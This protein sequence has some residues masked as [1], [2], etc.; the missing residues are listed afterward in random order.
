MPEII[1]NTLYVMTQGAYIHRDHL[2][3]KVEVEK[4]TRLAVPIHHLSSVAVFGSVMVSP[5]A[6]ELCLEAG[7]SLTFLS[8][9]GRLVAR[10]DAPVSGNVLLRREQFRWADRPE[11]CASVARNI[12]AGKLQNTR[13]VLLRGAREAKE[14]SDQAVLTS[15][16]DGIAESFRPLELAKTLDS[17]RG[18][19]GESARRY[20]GAFNH[21]LRQ[22]RAGFSISGRNRR[23]PLDPTNA[24]LSFTYALLLHDCVAAATSAGLDPNV[25]FLHEDR[26]GR[27]SLALD[28]ME[29]FRPLIADRLVLTLIN[30]QEIRVK[31]FKKRD[32]GA[33][34]M[35]DT[36]RK[37]LVTSWQ[38]RKQEEVTHPF[39]DQ[40]TTIG[41]LPF[42]QAKLLARH[43]RG[44]MPAYIPCILK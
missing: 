35:S 19:E 18:F 15:A 33:V 17:I 42:I 6:M 38:K 5:G 26:P 40:K 41:L 23:P 31:D 32:G 29:E 21:L 7:A 20:F 11:S 1:Q 30:R 28:L 9:T 13:G 10:V 34:E 4:E 12:V 43:I 25:G 3:I 16:A 8:E 22:D 24:M 37:T 14:S 36:A 27:P 44:D 2:T 39:L